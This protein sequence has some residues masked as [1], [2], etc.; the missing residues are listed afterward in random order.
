MSGVTFEILVVVSWIVFGLIVGYSGQ[1]LMRSRH[2]GS[3]FVSLL[4]G[5]IGA[6]IGGL[7]SRLIFGFGFKISNSP[8]DLTLASY[9]LSLAFALFVAILLDAIYR[10]MIDRSSAEG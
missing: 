8:E 7:L 2:T 9:I 5:A 3:T 10:I 4:L 1:F 6:V